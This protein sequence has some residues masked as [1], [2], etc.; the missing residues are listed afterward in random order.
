[1]YVDPC[2]SRLNVTRMDDET[3]HPRKVR[4][5]APRVRRFRSCT[6]RTVTKPLPYQ[7]SIGVNP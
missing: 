3:S 2:R 6:T 4:N 7:F 5:C 1:M